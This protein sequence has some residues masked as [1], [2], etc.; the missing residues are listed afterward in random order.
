[1][2]VLIQHKLNRL[3]WLKEVK[4]IPLYLICQ[5]TSIFIS[6]MLLSII[7]CKLLLHQKYFKLLHWNGVSWM[8]LDMMNNHKI[9][10]S[11][12]RLKIFFAQILV[13]KHLNYLMMVTPCMFKIFILTLLN[14]VTRHKMIAIANRK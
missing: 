11:N 9:I 4:L 6:P 13:I 7:Q 12:I 1:M 10:I 3:L 14:A 2:L 8:I 5:D